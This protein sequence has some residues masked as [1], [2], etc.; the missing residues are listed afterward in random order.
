MA[1]PTNEGEPSGAARRDT[2]TREAGDTVL[3]RETF[4][5]QCRTS[6]G[7]LWEMILEI[8]LD[9]R[10]MLL[11]A[12]TDLAAAQL[13][14]QELEGEAIAKDRLLHDKENEM[15]RI[16]EQRDRYAVRLADMVMGGD[17][18]SP[19]DDHPTARKTAKIPDPPMLSDGK[20]PQFDD[21]LVLM[22]Q[23]LAAN[24]DHYNTPE[25]RRAYVASR[26]EG[27]AAKHVSKRLREGAANRYTDSKDVLDHLKQV[28]HDPNRLANAKFKYRNLVMKGEKFHD[29]LTE[30][31]YLAEEAEINRD[32]WKEELYQK[33][34]AKLQELTI[35]EALRANGTFQE[36]ADYCSQTANR[37]EV[38]K[39]RSQRNCASYR[40]R[41]PVTKE[42]RQQRT[43]EPLHLPPELPLS[44]NPGRVAIP[45]WTPILANV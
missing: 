4:L 7:D 18:R 24:A 31:L 28:Y 8:H 42:Y 10:D 1:R 27:D 6:P 20:T 25:L 29:F 43:P 13:H 12:R 32:D 45:A 30:F 9:Y 35:P 15:A 26:C 37:L 44:V 36:F 38:I 39:N 33:L 21:W 11:D 2:L 23:K 14:S 16:T 40:P 5:E 17:H 22:E 19:G 41:P 34:T 3:G